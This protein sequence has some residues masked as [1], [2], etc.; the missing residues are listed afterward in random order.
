MVFLA[1][2]VAV[3]ADVVELALVLPVNHA[4][5]AEHPAEHRQTGT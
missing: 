5:V 1:V 3:D 2:D 4:V